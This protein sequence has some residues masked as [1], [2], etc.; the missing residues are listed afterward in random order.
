MNRHQEGIAGIDFCRVCF[1]SGHYN[2]RLGFHCRRIASDMS[3]A[4]LSFRVD[5]HRQR[6]GFFAAHS[7]FRIPYLKG[8]RIIPGQHVFSDSEPKRQFPPGEHGGLVIAA[9]GISR[10]L[11]EG[12]HI[13]RGRGFKWPDGHVIGNDRFY[14]QVRQFLAS[15]INEGKHNGY[16]FSIA[17][18]RRI[19]VV[20]HLQKFCRLGCYG[21]IRHHG[22]QLPL[23]FR[24]IGPHLADRH[25]RIG[26]I[27]V[28]TVK[29]VIQFLQRIRIRIRPLQNAVHV[30]LQLSVRFRPVLIRNPP[31]RRPVHPIRRISAC[32]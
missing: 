15:Q 20:S 23:H 18:G 13:S 7:F 17:D 30:I 28:C 3:G 29:R 14:H 12:L 21:Y 10:N 22:I 6:H 27:I 4:R 8:Y 5:I 31:V 1:K 24:N 19:P 2:S 9:K 32:G 26:N 25:F 16:L 11:S